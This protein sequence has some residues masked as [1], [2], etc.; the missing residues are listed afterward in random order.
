MGS[1]ATAALSRRAAL[2]GIQADTGQNHSAPL[3]M[4]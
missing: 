3:R 1:S 4:I 2:R